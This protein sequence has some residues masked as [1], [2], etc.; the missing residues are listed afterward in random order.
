MSGQIAGGSVE[1]FGGTSI[2]GELD[3]GFGT[4]EGGMTLDQNGE[5]SSDSK[6]IIGGEIGTPS[7]APVTASSGAVHTEVTSSKE[8]FNWKED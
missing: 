4:L 6:F 8:L 7:V 5:I 1:D 3:V 2:N